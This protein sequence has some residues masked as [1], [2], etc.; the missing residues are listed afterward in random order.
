MKKHTLNFKTSIFFKVLFVLGLFLFVP[1][2]TEAQFF[3]K[4]AKKAKEKI[5]READKRAER[6]VNKKIDKEFD[7]AEGVLDG[8]NKGKKKDKENGK[9]GNSNKNEKGANNSESTNSNEAKAKSNEPTVV[10]SKFDFVPGDTVIFEDGPSPDEE[11]GEFPSRWDLYKGSAEIANVN[12]E[13]VIMFIDR[14]GDI[15]PYLKNA[16]EDYLP[17]VFTIEFDVWFEKGHTTSNRFFISF[18]DKK[19]QWGKGLVGNFTVY[20]NG[21]EFEDTDKRYPGTEALSWAEEPIGQWRHISIAY[22]KGKF[23]AYMDDTRLINIPHLE[24]NPWGFTIKSQKGNQY[25]KNFRISK[26]GVKYYDRVLSEGKIIVNGIKFDVNKA[27]LKTESIGPIN[28]I[29]QLMVDNPTVNFSVEGHTDSDGSDETN[30]TLSKARG[31][32]VMDKLISM[33]ISS[34]RLKSNGFGE[35]KPLDNNSTPEGKANNRRVEFV[36][37]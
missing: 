12:G 6:R 30:M 2:Q 31:K 28:K 18:I 15:I 34:S 35:S 4:L 23:K 22:T 29:Y 33:G 27:T 25:L 11:N 37:F 10:W 21:I 32:T 1:Q 36:K 8:K 14:G 20:P 9:E 3:K 16:T 19:N 26:G 5:E 24:G 17:E 7:K 13:N